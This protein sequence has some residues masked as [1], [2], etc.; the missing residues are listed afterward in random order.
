MHAHLARQ[1]GALGDP[2]LCSAFA[3]SGPGRGEYTCKG[4]PCVL[5][6]LLLA[7]REDV[8]G[9]QVR[10]NPPAPEC[11]GCKEAA[12]RVEA[13]VSAWQEDLRERYELKK[14]LAEGRCSI[15]HELRQR[16]AE[17]CRSAHSSNTP[18]S[19]TAP[20]LLLAPDKRAEPPLAARTAR[21]GP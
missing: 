6:A 5:R 14:R 17:T 20:A 7:G 3:A 21:Q 16:R 11:A 15:T 2:L 1:A 12:V 10:D 8:R 4:K 9:V 19:T 13:V 18:A